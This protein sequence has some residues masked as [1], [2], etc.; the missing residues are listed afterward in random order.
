MHSWEELIIKTTRAKQKAKM[1]SASSRNIGQ[2]Y[3]YG[4]QPMHTRL[5][6]AKNPNKSKNKESK[7][8]AQELKPPSNSSGTTETSNKVWKEKKKY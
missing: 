3:Y 7:L 5:K 8:K 6:K 2:R 1:Q 4:N